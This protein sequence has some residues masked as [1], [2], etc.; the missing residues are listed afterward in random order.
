MIKVS[1]PIRLSLIY[2]EVL[3]SYFYYIS[4]NYYRKTEIKWTSVKIKVIY[5]V[6]VSYSY[7]SQVVK[8]PALKGC[9]FSS[10]LLT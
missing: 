9:C 5:E 10:D 7:V 2:Y 1:L 8:L 3:C 6:K 4:L